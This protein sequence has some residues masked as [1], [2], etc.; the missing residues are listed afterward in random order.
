MNSSRL[1]VS[2]CMITYNHEDFISDAIEG[3]LMQKADFNIELII[4]EDCSSDNTRNIVLQYA[5]KY[6]EIIRPLLQVKNLGMTNNFIDT[7]KAAKGKYIAVCE[8]DDFWTDPNKL[9]KQVNILESFP[10]II[11]VS[12]NS[13]VCDLTGTIIKSERLVVKPNN[14][15]GVHNLDDF[16]NKSIEYPTLTVMFRN[17]NMDFII[18]E[19]TNM[20]NPFLG[21]WILWVL[22]LTHGDFYFINQVTASYRMNP[23]SVTH[24]VNAVK[25]WETDFMIRRRLLEILPV[26]Y[27]KYLKDNTYAYHMMG[28]AYR[29]NK[30]LFLFIYYQII[31][32]LNNPRRL[33]FIYKNK[34][35]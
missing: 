20:N 35:L 6:P 10:H 4:G 21:D 15:E 12:T 7:L 26:E 8:G 19:L 2:V 28:M 25:R 32:L 24:S 34:F 27:H 11:A 9:Q 1:I 14:N 33:Y 17:Q 5:K 29:K 22:L 3:V 18:Q 16:F 13:S 31:A 30:N 23:N